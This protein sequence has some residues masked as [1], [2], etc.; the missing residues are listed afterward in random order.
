[1]NKKSLVLG[2]LALTFALG[3]TGIVQAASLDGAATSS[4]PAKYAKWTNR[5]ASKNSLK[6]ILIGKVTAI[7]GS[8]LTVVNNKK[9]AYTV[10]ISSAAI[11]EGMRSKAQAVTAADIKVGDRVKIAGT[12]NGATIKAVT[13]KIST[14][15]AAKKEAGKNA[16]GKRS[17]HKNGF[18]AKT[19]K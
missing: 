14:A 7:D 5:M 18:K 1:M 19:A 6:P 11:T 13:V 3:S 12:L 8:S 17:G 4:A 2:A 16:K 10:D 15:K 9:A